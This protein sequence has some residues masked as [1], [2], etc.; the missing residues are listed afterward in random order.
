[1]KSLLE[2]ILLR[3]VDHPEDLEITEV[4]EMGLMVYKLKL[5]PD[6]IGRVIGRGGNV[7]K[8]IR[9]LAQVRAVKDHL[10]VRV[11]LQEE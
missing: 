9:K 1:M 7:I 11:V 4:E 8:A 6:D 2:F 10:R 5:H 3:M